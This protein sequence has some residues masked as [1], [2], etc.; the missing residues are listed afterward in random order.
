MSEFT[1]EERQAALDEADKEMF[2]ITINHLLQA[3]NEIK[4]IT[5]GLT[6]FNPT[7]EKIHNIAVKGLEVPK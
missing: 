4:D 5:S 3:L 2:G 6:E 7:Y 1:Y